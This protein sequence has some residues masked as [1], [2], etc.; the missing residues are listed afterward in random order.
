MNKFER[1]IVTNNPVSAKKYEK[2]D[3]VRSLKPGKTVR[4]AESHPDNAH[5]T[6]IHISYRSTQKARD[7]IGPG[8]FTF[9]SDPSP[10]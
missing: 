10:L 8:L 1:V 6:L 7:L 5:E 2:T 9:I 4:S 3:K